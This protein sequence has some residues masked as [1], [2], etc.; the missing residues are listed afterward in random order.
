MNVFIDLHNLL[1]LQNFE[2]HFELF[3]EKRRPPAVLGTI[4]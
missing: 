2:F 1:A 4:N 3:E